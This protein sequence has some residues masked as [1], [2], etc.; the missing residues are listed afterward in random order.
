[1]RNVILL[2]LLIIC[3]SII[4]NKLDLCKP[5]LIKAGAVFCQRGITLKKE[6]VW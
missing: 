6:N 4:K 5:K 2:F 1:M 3:D